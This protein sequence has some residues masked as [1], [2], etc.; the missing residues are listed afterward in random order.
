MRKHQKSIR[1]VHIAEELNLTVNRYKYFVTINHMIVHTSLS[2]QITP[3][4][5][6]FFNFLIFLSS[7]EWIKCSIATWHSATTNRC[8]VHFLN[9]GWFSVFV[10][11][12]TENSNARCVLRCLQY[13]K[14]ERWTWLSWQWL[15][16]LWPE[17]DTLRDLQVSKAQIQP[18]WQICRRLPNQV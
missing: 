12:C 15:S 6:Y 3:I 17:E 7:L 11:F 1:F 14:V 5:E 4:K 2:V 9:C 16:S 13:V 18:D 8:V 10:S